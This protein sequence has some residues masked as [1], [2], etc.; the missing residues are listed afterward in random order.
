MPKAVNSNSTVATKFQPAHLTENLPA[1]LN[2]LQACRLM[3]ATLSE[4]G[5]G[6][7]ITLADIDK[8]LDSLVKRLEHHKDE[9][10]PRGLA[11]P[12]TIRSLRNAYIVHL[13][14]HGFSVREI[15]QALNM[16]VKAI[17][18]LIAKMQDR[19]RKTGR[20]VYNQMPPMHT[21]SLVSASFAD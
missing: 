15:A 12:Q 1:L 18:R 14:W 7:K 8:M 5:H 16:Q 20:S 21:R 3:L 11:Y 17:E 19:H 13:L 2:S 9:M 10:M 6:P 4:T